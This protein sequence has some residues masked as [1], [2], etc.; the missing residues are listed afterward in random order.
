MIPCL[1]ISLSRHQERR[2]S[3]NAQMRRLG[4]ECVYIEAVDGARL[5]EPAMLERLR[6]EFPEYI[7]G[8]LEGVNLPAGEIGCYLSQLRALHYLVINRLDYALIVEDDAVFN[9]DDPRIFE[10]ITE[11]DLRWDMIKLAH[12][13]HPLAK[14]PRLARR[15]VMGR[16]MDFHFFR[17]GIIGTTANLHCRDGAIKL[18]RNLPRWGLCLPVDALIERNRH[19]MDYLPLFVRPGLAHENPDLESSLV[20]GRDNR[21]A[22]T[23]YL[24]NQPLWPR[25][26]RQLLNI[27][28]D[29]T[30]PWKSAVDFAG[31]A[32]WPWYF[33]KHML[34]RRAP[35]KPFDNYTLLGSSV[36]SSNVHLFRQLGVRI[37][38]LDPLMAPVDVLIGS[39]YWLLKPSQRPVMKWWLALNRQRYEFRSFAAK[40]GEIPVMAIYYL[41]RQAG[42]YGRWQRHLLLLRPSGVVMWNGW[43]S[44]WTRDVALRG[45]RPAVAHWH[46][47]NAPLPGCLTMD[48]Q[49]VNANSYLPRNPDF[50]RAWRRQNPNPAIDW[51]ALGQQLRQRPVSARHL[52]SDLG[53]ID[54]LP[55]KFIFV[56]LQMQNDSQIYLHSGWVH[57]IDNFIRL[58]YAYCNL[59]PKDWA[60]ILK[61]HPS[62]RDIEP[63][64][65]FQSRPE[66][67]YNGGN[68]D[69]VELL[70]KCSAL[71]N[72]NGSMGLQAYFHDKPV[73]VLGDNFY[74]FGA[75]ARQCKSIA[76][77]RDCFEGIDTLGFDSEQRDS[78][79]SFLVN[80]YYL[81]VAPELAS[82]IVSSSLR[83]Y[84]IDK[85]TLTQVTERLLGVWDPWA[86]L[87][88][89]EEQ[90]RRLAE[91][92]IA[93]APAPATPPR[94]PRSASAAPRKAASQHKASASNSGDSVS[95]SGKRAESGGSASG[96]GKRAESGGSASGSGKKAESGPSASGSGKRAE[97]GGIAPGPG[98]KSGSASGSGKKA[99]SG[100]SA[101]GSGKRAESGGIAPGS[102]KKSGSASGSGKKA[103]SGGSASGSGKKAESGPSASGSGK[104]AE[105]GGS[106]SGPG[107]KAGSA[108]GSGKKAES[109]PSASGSGKRAESGGIAPGS[110][111]KSGSASGSG[112][113][114]ESGSSASGS[115][116]R[117]ESGGSASGS[118][119]KAGSASGS[120][121]K[122]ESG[123]SASG[124]GKRAESGGSASGS[125]KKAGSASGSGKKAGSASGSGKKAGSASG[126]G[127]KAG[128]ASGSGKKAGSASGSGKKAGSASGSGKKAG[129][130][131]GSGKKASREGSAS[132]SG[133][134]AES[135]SSASG[136]GKK[137]KA[138]KGK[139]PA[140]SASKKAGKA[141]KKKAGG[142]QDKRSGGKS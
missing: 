82:R 118:G 86:G 138:A 140:K 89:D 68:F 113:K 102:G 48:P 40:P 104:R 115:G 109:G 100:P 60:V 15:E 47:E 127:K 45:K 31:K 25:K 131:S 117:A 108:S 44:H 19:K 3:I 80:H 101:S 51:R 1:V 75:M 35:T 72:I 42:Y 132:G 70:R 121:K 49:G 6:E 63:D 38:W 32:Q 64:V 9:T 53:L 85:H 76:D 122:A 34:F 124:S 21:N 23:A 17:R 135:G 12:T 78:F 123:S 77:L 136:S 95:G 14:G 84:K 54:E 139:A 66:G 2:Q 4:I 137:R 79:M 11:L 20:A 112:K 105:S 65:V 10:E 130:A 52:T 46:F 96:P 71:V 37:P 67:V 5:G 36:V 27:A 62:D 90:W 142:R 50:Y 28:K 22:F 110:G 41:L 98:K 59:L 133:K 91:A 88:Q 73:V 81:H 83:G 119:K 134:K 103:E 18:L 29:L 55:E 26:R 99:E 16:Q 93:D 8:S 58:I 61:T 111:K 126:S 129:S 7:D 107:K 94:Q 116:K 106:A 74:G 141:P 30:T 57:S 33:A 24:R 43:R 13:E 87:G 128:S 114:A 39:I 69:S 97:S 125:G 92:P 56:P 120:G